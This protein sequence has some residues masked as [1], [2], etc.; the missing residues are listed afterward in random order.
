MKN[1]NIDSNRVF[2]IGFSAGTSVVSELVEKKPELWNG[3]I[4]NNP[5]RLPKL[6]EV[7]AKYPRILI[8]MGE[9][10]KA[11]PYVERFTHEAQQRLIPVEKVNHSAA[12]HVFR[13]IG[14]VKDRN[15]RIADFVSIR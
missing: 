10:E 13:N 8:S 9:A 5:S 7:L 11:E 3:V 2:L 6:P 12:G 15:R 4:L 1:S 14:L